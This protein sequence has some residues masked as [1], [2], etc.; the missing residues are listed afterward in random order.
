MTFEKRHYLETATERVVA[1]CLL[2]GTSVSTA[3]KIA[4]DFAKAVEGGV[5]PESLQA[6]VL[7]H[8]VGPVKAHAMMTEQ[9]PTSNRV[10]DEEAR[11]VD[12]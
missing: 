1:A 7:S 9:P 12:L 5:D 6:T 2:A 11:E 10:D 8:A 3:Y 4:A